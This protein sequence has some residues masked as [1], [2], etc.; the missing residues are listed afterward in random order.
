MKKIT[1]PKTLQ[2]TEVELIKF[3]LR[4][5]L[6]GFAVNETELTILSYIYLY[7]YDIDRIVKDGVL[8]SIK[9]VENYISKFRKN[10]IIIGLK[11]ETRLNPSIKL[12][13]ESI[14]FTINLELL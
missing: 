5:I 12:F 6:Q 13:K 9:S 7:G 10:K 2:V 4:Y 11:E 3:Q 14:S 1:H 8:S